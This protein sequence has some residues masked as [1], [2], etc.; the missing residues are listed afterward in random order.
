MIVYERRQ[1]DNNLRRIQAQKRY[2]QVQNYQELQCQ[3]RPA[4]QLL[5]QQGRT[6]RPAGACEDMRL[7]R[8]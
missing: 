5:Q 4:Q 1:G 8:M 6:D 3:L 2:Q 7:P